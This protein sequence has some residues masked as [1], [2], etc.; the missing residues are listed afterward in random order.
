MEWNVNRKVSIVFVYTK[1]YIKVNLIRTL[2]KEDLQVIMNIFSPILRRT[3]FC[4]VDPIIFCC[5][6]PDILY[7]GFP[8]FF[9]YTFDP[10]FARYPHSMTQ[11]LPYGLN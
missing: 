10:P 6:V 9:F 7:Y 3:F 8:F 1:V 2:R 11:I 4:P 5:F